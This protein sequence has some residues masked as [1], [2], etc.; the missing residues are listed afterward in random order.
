MRTCYYLGMSKI[1]LAT[2]L[3]RIEIARCDLDEQRHYLG[4]AARSAADAVAAFGVE[5]TRVAMGTGADENGYLLPELM[6]A[7][8]ETDAAL[9]ELEM[10]AA[11]PT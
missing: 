11:N 4:A 2:A 5:L 3:S 1:T 6:A 8:S 10:I 7:K 9:V